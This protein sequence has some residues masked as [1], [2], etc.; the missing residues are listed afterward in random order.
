VSDPPP[1]T[2]P[3]RPPW[4]FRIIR[5]LL[6][7][8]LFG[9]LMLQL[10]A[11]ERL[12]SRQP[13][14]LPDFLQNALEERL[15]LEGVSVRFSSMELSITGSLWLRQPR[16]YLAGTP[17]PVAEADLL[18]IEPDWL[19][20]AWEHKLV[21][22]RLGLENAHLYCPPEVSPSGVRETIVSGFDLTLANN[23]GDWWRLD[24]LNAHIL[25]TRV[26]A[27]GTFIVPPRKAAPATAAAS[28]ATPAA[29]ATSAPAAPAA[30]KPTLAG[31]YRSFA[32]QLEN[33]QEDFSLAQN[34]VVAL[35][36]EAQ[37]P[38]RTVIRVFAQVD[39]A[40]PP[41]ENANL[42]LGRLW[43]RD[44]A[45]WDG[46]TVRA[47]L[48]AVCRLDTIDFVERGSDGTQRDIVNGGPAWVRVQLAD[49]ANGV[50]ARP[51]LAWFML[52]PVSIY[53]FGFDSMASAV[54]L[55]SDTNMGFTYFA[56]RD[57][58]WLKATGVGDLK[59]ETMTLDVD[60]F[61]D[62]SVVLAAARQKAPKELASLKFARPPRLSGHITLAPG[63]KPEALDFTLLTGGAQYGNIQLY[64]LRARGRLTPGQIDVQ[65]A[66]LWNGTW[67]VD[68]SYT[69]D[70][71]TDDFRI[72]ARG[73]LDPGV[74][75]TY[76]GKWWP[77][78]W[79][80]IVPGANWPVADIDY[81]GCWDN[82]T[83]ETFYGAVSLAGAQAHGVPLDN[84]AVRVYLRK[85]VDAVFD[86]RAD[87]HGGG[88]FT[89]TMLWM[90]KPPYKKMYEQRYMFQST[91]PL[92]SAASLAGP[93]VVELT[94][95][96]HAPH[97]P[98]VLVD[99]RTGGLVNPQAN[100]T[101]TKL[102]V[103][104][105]APF[106]AYSVPVDWLQGNATLYD[107][108]SDIPEL[109]F[110]LG[111]GTATAKAT[112]T[113]LSTGSELAFNLT[114]AA[115]HHTSVLYALSQF[116]VPGQAHPAG[117]ATAPPAAAAAPGNATAKLPAAGTMEDLSRPGKMDLALGGRVLLGNADSFVATGHAK[118]YEAKL[119]QLQFFGMLSRLMS[120]TIIP[121]G[122]FDL[123]TA[124][125]DIQ[126][127]HEY[128]RLPNVRV[129]GPDMRIVSAGLY[130]FQNEQM[131][132]NALMF[133]LGSWTVPV[134]SQIINFM[135][136]VNNAFTIKL[137]GT[138]DNPDWNVGM[139]PLRI[140]TEKNLT[141][142]P[143]PGFPSNPD[144]S[145]VIPAL[146][147]PPPNLPALVMPAATA[148]Q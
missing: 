31:Q 141:A 67:H 50:F 35:H 81:I 5:A 84:L 117:N 57:R 77:Q 132:F 55:T 122:S 73:S 110:G 28:A 116:K 60:A 93:D 94:R 102:G 95:P 107:D 82:L 85:D 16:I 34:P 25:N 109:D 75:N 36:L 136:S 87:E 86:I 131:N 111:N 53:G 144:G 7:L 62:P 78:V 23:G 80:F 89:G 101:V 12:H 48:P 134:I 118:I 121:I 112:V 15:R 104:M 125:S 119:G 63:Y 17:D 40:Q 98:S 4:W 51:P 83:T 19:A 128:A 70:L 61:V 106:T 13:L 115:G 148:A 90:R 45:V 11:L 49:G 64:A 69:Q 37:A 29:P 129:T 59:N 1:A 2:A 142:P 147:F 114:L 44:T 99:T 47:L 91:L 33:L 96:L 6:N 105:P 65:E 10:F 126:I 8:A 54:T 113:R 139:N 43:V 52:S 127:A 39:G 24:Y 143:I 46:Q 146:P 135:S 74:L 123:D 3:V 20:L 9:V 56:V 79:K 145:P 38:D 30:A 120:G 26:L 97:A 100:V 21:L 41:V 108:F 103:K 14:Q 92:A 72:R 68:G 130:D 138:L 58:Y 88:Q 71:H 76:I 22:N 18:L 32:R 124:T 42:T 137:T 140:F 66:S 27:Q 133:P